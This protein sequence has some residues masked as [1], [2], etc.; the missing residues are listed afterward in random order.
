MLYLYKVSAGYNKNEGVFE[1]CTTL[2]K[3][4]QDQSALFHLTKRIGVILGIVLL[5]D[6][7]FDTQLQ[8]ALCINIQRNIALAAGAEYRSVLAV[9][10]AVVLEVN[11][12]HAAADF[13]DVCHSVHAGKLAPCHIQNKFPIRAVFQQVVHKT[14]IAVNGPPV[15]LNDVEFFKLSFPT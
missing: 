7:I 1:P 15:I 3:L 12:V 2:E 11:A 6:H 10:A 5:C 4:P 8:D 13:F 9:D 14:V